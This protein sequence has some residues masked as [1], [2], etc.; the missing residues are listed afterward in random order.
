MT[1]Q[2]DVTALTF[3]VEFEPCEL[4]VRD[5]WPDGDAPENPTVAHVV[6]RMIEYGPAWQTIREWNLLTDVTVDGVTV[7]EDI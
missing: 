1:E 4:T 3:T 7:W 2:R 6:E 5:I